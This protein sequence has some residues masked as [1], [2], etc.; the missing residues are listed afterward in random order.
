EAR[1]QGANP[2]RLRGPEMPSGP[3]AENTCPLCVPGCC[4]WRAAGTQA[5]AHTPCLILGVKAV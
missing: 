3:L 5:P 4:R 1:F 2:E